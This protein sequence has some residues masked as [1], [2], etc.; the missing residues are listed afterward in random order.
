MY[1]NNHI[2]VLCGS[3]VI[4]INVR[5]NDGSIDLDVIEFWVSKGVIVVTNDNLRII[6]EAF[7]QS[8]NNASD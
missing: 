7:L 5:A 2:S 8:R 6:I 4:A 3:Q 1:E